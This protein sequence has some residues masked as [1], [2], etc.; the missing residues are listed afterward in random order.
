MSPLERRYRAL[1][2]LFP[3]EHRRA[4]GDD[5]LGTLL[6][7]APAGRAWPTALESFDLLL[8]AARAHAV[9]MRRQP[10][11]EVLRSGLVL[12][13]F[14]LAALRLG[15]AARW[16]C[17]AAARWFQQGGLGGS[18][19]D[20]QA[21]QRLLAPLAAAPLLAVFTVAVFAGRRR[22][23]LAA[24]LGWMTVRA[25]DAATYGGPLSLSW[26]LQHALPPVIPLGLATLW[27]RPGRSLPWAALPLSV[28]VLGAAGAFPMEWLHHLPRGGYSPSA[29]L[30]L[31][32]LG[33]L[34]SGAALLRVVDPRWW[35]LPALYAL[36]EH[37]RTLLHASRTVTEAP[38]HLAL[39]ASTHLASVALFVA[40]AVLHW[41]V[42][43]APRRV[44]VADEDE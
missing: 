16:S 24:T 21:V 30:L 43:R 11:G 19:G 41:R 10:L 28:G 17:G 36:E 2:E 14:L 32:A 34:L 20:S 15:G 29:T 6:D 37:S 23:A 42:Q 33:A 40:C 44:P 13:A 1:I 4:W 3:A 25:W 27:L 22:L 31:L 38:A 12:A 39:V 5:L 9:A 26:V 7:A 8:A 35:L 18:E